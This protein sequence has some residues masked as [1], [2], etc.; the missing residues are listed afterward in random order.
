MNL[1]TGASLLAL[2]KSI[3]YVLVIQLSEA[4]KIRMPSL[5]LF[6]KLKERY[7]P[8]FLTALVLFQS[9]KLVW[10]RPEE[11]IATGSP[12]HVPYKLKEVLIVSATTNEFAYTH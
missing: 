4:I 1:L 5:I 6:L 7:K 10:W 12:V 2:A 11:T 9:A 3:Y 8:L